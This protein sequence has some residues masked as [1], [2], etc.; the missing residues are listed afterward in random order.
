MASSSIIPYINNTQTVTFSQV[1]SSVEKT[2]YKVAGRPL[3]TPYQLELA[4]KLVSGSKNDHIT[5]RLSRV[6][7][8]INTAQLATG[9]ILV[10]ISVPKDQSIL[11][12]DILKEMLGV[13]ASLCNDN[14]ALAATSNSRAALVD[15]R[16]L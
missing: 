9:Q 16:D 4:R 15:G 12:P 5:V 7:Q 2:V 14:A 13:I 10:D 11:T 6:E 1:A 3:A 8:N